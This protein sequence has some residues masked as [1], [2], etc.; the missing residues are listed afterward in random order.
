VAAIRESIE[1]TTSGHAGGIGRAGRRTHDV[2]DTN[3]D[4]ASF[5][6]WY[7]AE[8]PRLLATLTVACGDRHLAQDVTSEAFARALAAWRR[9]STMGEPSG[10]TYRVAVNLLHRRARRAATEARLLASLET[11]SAAAPSGLEAMEV[12]DAVGALP[13]RERLAIALR[14]AAG[15]TEAEVASAMGIAVGTASSTL[16]SARRRLALTLHDEDDEP[17]RAHG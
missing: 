13:A 9:V 11:T 12:W 17:E 6:Q 14:Y 2:S 8:H 10:W 7:R 16:T 3:D 5:E 1:P 15:L 4:L